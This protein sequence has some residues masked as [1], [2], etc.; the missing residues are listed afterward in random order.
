MTTWVALIATCA[1]VISN[2]VGGLQPHSIHSPQDPWGL[3]GLFLILLGI[4]L[5]TWSAGIIRKTEVLS[6]AG[7]YALMRHP[8]YVGS[9]FIALGFCTVIGDAKTF[10]IILG[11]LIPLHV[12]KTI[13]EEKRLFNRF[14]DAWT[15]Y[16]RQTGAFYPKT[17][18]ILS[19][20]LSPWSASQWLHNQEYGAFVVGL[21]ALLFLDFWHQYPSFGAPIK[22]MFH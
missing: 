21:V 18:P 22:A 9:F 5:R 12:R 6:T 13:R 2:I 17:V 10:I 16:K 3:V 20:V 8:L 4:F 1:L 11:L 19:K 15:D 14:G 7:P